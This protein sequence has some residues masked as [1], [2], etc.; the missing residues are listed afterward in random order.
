MKN[1]EQAK[2][3]L[4]GSSVA[5]PEEEDGSPLVR[6]P[7]WG[8]VARMGAGGQEQAEGRR[9]TGAGGGGENRAEDGASGAV[10]SELFGGVKG[11]PVQTG[12]SAVRILFKLLGF[13]LTV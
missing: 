3:F 4:R 12:L 9:G 10:L 7:A 1:Y 8:Y 6:K 11:E 13:L 5:W 2:K